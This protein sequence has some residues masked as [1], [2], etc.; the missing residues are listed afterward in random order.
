MIVVFDTNIWKTNLYLRSSA[1]A[2]VKLFLH[3]HTAKV[4]LPEVIRLEVEWHLRKD[5]QDMRDQISQNY[6]RLLGLFGRLPEVV[7]P[8][9]DEIEAVI[10][11]VFSQAG[12]EVLDVPFAEK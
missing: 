12:F 9:D 6:N 3:M 2:A 4:G 7:L 5:I 10:A 11:N 8:T 1:A